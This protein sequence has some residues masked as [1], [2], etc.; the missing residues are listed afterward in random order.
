MLHNP[1]LSVHHYPPASLDV[2]VM[3]ARKV[4]YEVRSA[5][6]DMRQTNPALW[7]PHFD[8]RTF[9]VLAKFA[10]NPHI[11]IG[12]L[13][14]DIAAIFPF[15]GRKHGLIRPLG[16]PMSDQHG[17][18]KRP[19]CTISLAQMLEKAKVSGLV[20][21]GMLEPLD[22]SLGEEAAQCHVADLSDGIEAFK[23]WQ[24][25][26]WKDQVKKNARR[27]RM[28]EANWGPMRI[29]IA[30]PKTSNHFDTLLA[31]KQ[32]KYIETNRHNVL[33]V[34]WIKN[35]LLE[36]YHSQDPDFRGEI[37]CLYFGEHL[38]ALEFGL[39]AG[40]AMHSWFPAF[41]RN[42]AQVSPGILLMD[43]MIEACAQRGITKVD[44]GIGH[45]QY[46]RHASNAPITVYG[47]SLPLSPLRR[48]SAKGISW[49]GEQSP[50]NGDGADLLGRF[51]RRHEMILASEPTAAGRVKGYLAALKALSPQR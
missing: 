2:A 11:L 39:R 38:A 8:L 3:D 13:D 22:Q 15:Q 28:G 21:S 18:I 20:Y 31:W 44:L 14:G 30:C 10:T 6:Q 16:A 40:D 19:D 5:W 12:Y 48:V 45:A 42:Y 50:F 26:T 36:L 4:P 33:G 37:T 34:P 32:A 47:G 46:K 17:L 35:C 43:G 24:A 25:A 29:E 41:D 9:D 23:A 27:I 7:S 1:A 49:L 51:Q